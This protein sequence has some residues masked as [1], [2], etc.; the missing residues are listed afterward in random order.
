MC[1]G[2]LPRR[3]NEN[4][5]GGAKGA[6]LDGAVVYTPVRMDRVLRAIEA[7]L[8]LMTPEGRTAAAESFRDLVLAA[9]RFFTKG[10]IKFGMGD[11][12]H[13]LGLITQNAATGRGLDALFTQA[14]NRVPALGLAHVAKFLS[15]IPTSGL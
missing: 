2:A 15:F 6:F 3:A 9:R 4:G 5:A 10:G 8:A 13:A 11:G 12:L 14:R 7:Q 1:G